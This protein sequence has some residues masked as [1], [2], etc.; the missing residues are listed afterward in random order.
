MEEY[1]VCPFSSSLPLGAVLALEEFKRS[2]V[3]FFRSCC[4]VEEGLVDGI[5]EGAADGA[6]DESA[7]DG[8]ADDEGWGSFVVS[9]EFWVEVGSIVVS[10]DV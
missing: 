4:G 10:V 6:D 7:D 1:G 2:F 5:D 8:S 3:S 9:V